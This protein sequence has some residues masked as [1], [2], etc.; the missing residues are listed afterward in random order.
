MKDFTELNLSPGSVDLY[1]HRASIL[2][3]LKRNLL[4]FHG[5]FLDVGCGKMPYKKLILSQSEVKN[6]V[7]LD[8]ETAKVYDE[9]V[10]PDVRWDGKVIPLD[11]NSF[12]TVMATEVL[13]HCP[14]PSAI[15][16]EIHRVLRPG[17]YFFFT[18]PF[19]WNLHEQPYD[20]YRYT[21]YALELLLKNAGFDDIEL[22]PQGGWHASLAQMLGLWM[23]RSPYAHSR[24]M[25]LIRPVLMMMYT[26]L[27]HMS[28]K[29]QVDLTKPTML[30][31]IYGG[32]RKL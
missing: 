15:L 25:K 13:E 26:R 20:F 12:D 31:A 4:K 16:E 9:N 30:T 32:A 27:L 3:A 8:I 29:E 14:D 5:E 24:K 11:D 22:E 2:G 28:K 17:G 6:Y 1:Y 7:G 10:Q 21:P 19:L 23:K 18:V